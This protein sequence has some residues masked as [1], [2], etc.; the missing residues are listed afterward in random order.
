MVRRPHLNS[1][2]PFQSIF[3]CVISN[4][5]EK[6]TLSESLSIS[7]SEDK[8]QELEDQQT[9]KV[10]S[11]ARAWAVL[12]QSPT[13]N[14]GQA[15]QLL[16]LT[17]VDT[18]SYQ[19]WWQEWWVQSRQVCPEWYLATSTSSLSHLSVL[20]CFQL[21]PGMP[22]PCVVK[23]GAQSNPC[24]ASRLGQL[25]FTFWLFIWFPQPHCLFEPNDG[26]QNM[27]IHNST[28]TSLKMSEC[29]HMQTQQSLWQDI[30]VAI[31]ASCV[32]ACVCVCVRAR[33]CPIHAERD[34]P[35]INKGPLETHNSWGADVICGGG[36]C[37][38]VSRPC[39][40]ISCGP[41]ITHTLECNPSSDVLAYLCSTSCQT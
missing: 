34:D 26:E 32:D 30:V 40:P 12:E 1:P 8:L 17:S 21:W 13:A 27:R 10:T 31:T 36:G 29:T 38:L 11:A 16:S 35:S 23:L 24:T 41:K 37:G 14:D 28:T 9:R 22:S 2:R 18:A 19:A 15:S 20:L 5:T 4:T 6:V 39:Q 33:A 7:I 3:A 25:Q